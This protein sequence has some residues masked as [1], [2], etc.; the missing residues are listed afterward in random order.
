MNSSPCRHVLRALPADELIKSHRDHF[1]WTFPGLLR[2]S[3]DKFHL[4]LGKF[5]R[6]FARW[7]EFGVHSSPRFSTA[8]SRI[9]YSRAY[10]LN[11]M[12]SAGEFWKI[13]RHWLRTEIFSIFSIKSLRT[14]NK[15]WKMQGMIEI[16]LAC[17][18]GEQT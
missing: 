13:S 6:D 10:T 9:I 17:G 14:F 11:A 2:D 4:L 3:P 5:N 12:K 7:G 15:D 18:T 1:R 16:P 8:R